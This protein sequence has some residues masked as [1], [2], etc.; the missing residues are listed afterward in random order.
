MNGSGH[1]ESLAGPSPQASKVVYKYKGNFQHSMVFGVVKISG[2]CRNNFDDWDCM[3]G[4][5]RRRT[6]A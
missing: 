4:L 2:W 3:V 1:L 6:W 5:Q